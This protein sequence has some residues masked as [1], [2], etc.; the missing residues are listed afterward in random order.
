VVQ[1]PFPQPQPQRRGVPIWAWIIGGCG[2]AL[3]LGLVLLVIG[4]II[5]AR[6]FQ[7]GGLTCLPKD[8]PVY[9]G[10][11]YQNV[12]TNV[13][14]GGS[15]CIVTLDAGASSTDV[16]AYYQ[17]HLAS[18]SWKATG[19]DPSQGV[20]RFGRTDNARATGRVAF[21]GHGTRTQV[22][23]EYDH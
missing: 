21:L 6:S 20:L 12:R 11:T 17:Q 15:S 4:G 1:Q 2:V 19:Y 10:A 9:P 23:I 22:D 14:T 7:A 5:L 13:G 8:F 18:G 16:T 3:V